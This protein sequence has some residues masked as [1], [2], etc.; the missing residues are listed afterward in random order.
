[1]RS[2]HEKI[3][4]AQQKL[5]NTQTKDLNLIKKRLEERLNKELKKREL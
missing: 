3:Y 1:M 4:S 5:L 2:R